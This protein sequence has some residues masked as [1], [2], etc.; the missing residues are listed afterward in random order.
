MDPKIKSTVWEDDDFAALDDVGKVIFFWLITCQATNNIGYLEV[1]RRAFKVDTGRDYKELERVLEGLPRAYV[2]DHHHGRVRV[3]IRN[4]IKHQ[5][6]VGMLQPKSLMFTHIRNLFADLP[7]PFRTAFA[8]TYKPLVS[9]FQGV[10]IMEGACKGFEGT[11]TAQHRS[12]QN[13]TDPSGESEG[14]NAVIP[15]M[16]EFLSAF[17]ADGI[18]PSYLERQ[19]EKFHEKKTW[20]NGRGILVDWRRIVRNYWKADRATWKPA[21]RPASDDIDE[22]EMRD[23]IPV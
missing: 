10:S 7:D 21:K 1:S 6:P 5:W 8:V 14:G 2:W 12:E 18:P 15:T 16:A 11:R 13:S 23:L 9:L 19:F 22:T 20:F 3:W 17:T 4:Y